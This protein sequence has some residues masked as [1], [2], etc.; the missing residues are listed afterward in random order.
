MAN[1]TFVDTSGFYALLVKKDKMHGK[2]VR[3]LHE[4]AKR[5]KRYITSDYILD[6]T[7]TLLKARGLTHILPDFF[8]TI[9]SSKACHIEWMDQ[10]RFLDTR[11]YFLKHSDQSCS[12]T[13][14][15]SFVLMKELKMSE[16]MTKDEHFRE[17]G[18]IPILT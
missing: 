7:A 14:C 1:E 18:F 6:E 17:A 2:A 13:D 15:F 8:D 9:F 10:T 5:N 3:Y 16:A 12:F 11:N 4:K